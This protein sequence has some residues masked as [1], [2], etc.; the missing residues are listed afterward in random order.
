MAIFNSY[1]KLP[2]VIV[3]GHFPS[4]SWRLGRF[5]SDIFR[6]FLMC[7]LRKEDG[8]DFLSF[9]SDPRFCL[10]LLFF[11]LWDRLIVV[12]LCVVLVLHGYSMLE[13]GVPPGTSRFGIPRCFNPPEEPFLTSEE[14]DKLLNQLRA[15]N[16]FQK[17]QYDNQTANW[18]CGNCA[19]IY[20]KAGMGSEVGNRWFS[21]D[22]LLP[23]AMLT[24]YLG[25]LGQTY[26][27]IGQDTKM[28]VD[29]P[30]SCIGNDSISASWAG[31]FV[32]ASTHAAKQLGAVFH[33]FP[34]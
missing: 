5:Q 10:F 12:V 8:E 21:C 20:L 31:G 34:L 13:D 22:M 23:G 33:I 25:T 27:K 6:N 11:F 15:A 29:P 24:R 1:V 14:Q 2:E 26:S 9:I 17:F 28:N 32:L 18:L 4:P 3:I 19:C 16:F 30:S 7:Q